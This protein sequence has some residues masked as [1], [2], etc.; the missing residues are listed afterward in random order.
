V[1]VSV[2]IKF[3]QAKNL[4]AANLNHDDSDGK[5]QVKRAEGH[6]NR[7]CASVS[8]SVT[9]HGSSCNRRLRA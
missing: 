4:N 9:G 8:A 5:L 2:I 6:G 7:P 1:S 3:T